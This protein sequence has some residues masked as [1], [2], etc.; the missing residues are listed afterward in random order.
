LA[1]KKESPWLL[2]GFIVRCRDDIMFSRFDRTT[3][4]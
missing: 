4:C 2:V 3:T 1:T